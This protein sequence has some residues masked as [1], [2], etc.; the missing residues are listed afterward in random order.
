[1][2][3]TKTI[4]VIQFNERNWPYK[5]FEVEHFNNITHSLDKFYEWQD[6]RAT[7]YIIA[8]DRRKQKLNNIMERSIYKSIKP[9]IQFFAY[10]NLMKQYENLLTEKI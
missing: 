7:F 6:F 9:Y 4:D 10:N 8:D 5:F 2:K 3:R 1:M